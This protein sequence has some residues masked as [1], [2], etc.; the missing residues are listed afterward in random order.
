MSQIKL[1]IPENVLPGEIIELKALIRHNMESGYR[2]DIDGEKI[3]RNILTRFECRLDGT[4]LFSADLNP[5]VSANPL[6]K[7]HLRAET[8]GTLTF[9]W[10]EQTGK[11]FSK[12]AELK[13]GA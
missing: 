9:E 7:F 5:G 8:S 3:P 6:I 12:T 13:I 2:L 11:I 4:P 1:S 10:T